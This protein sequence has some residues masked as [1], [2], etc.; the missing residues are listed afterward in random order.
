MEPSFVD[1]LTDRFARAA[2]EMASR[3]TANPAVSAAARKKRKGKKKKG[4]VNRRCKEQAADVRTLVEISCG[5]DVE[6]QERGLTCVG[7]LATCDFNGFLQ[8]V[9]DQNNPQ[10]P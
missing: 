2:R 3:T 7:P 1:A 4:D 6:C 10:E 8:C 5:D 9:A